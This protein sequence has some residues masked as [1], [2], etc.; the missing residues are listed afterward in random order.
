VNRSSDSIAEYRR[1]RATSA[2]PRPCTLKRGSTLFFVRQN[3]ATS[4]SIV[5]N[6][7]PLAYDKTP[8]TSKQDANIPPTISNQCF[9][10]A[11]YWETR[12]DHVHCSP[13]RGHLSPLCLRR[14][15]LYS[16]PF[17]LAYDQTPLISKQDKPKISQEKK[18]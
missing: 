5:L 13:K 12:L 11:F 7:L 14:Y 17:P 1:Q 4:R 3:K 15:P 16:T 9:T 8:L 2:S 10:S 18:V 6:T